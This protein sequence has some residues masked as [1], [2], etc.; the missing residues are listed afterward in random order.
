[1]Y[2]KLYKNMF[3]SG[4]SQKFT[5]KELFSLIFKV[6]AATASITEYKHVVVLAKNSDV[7]YLK[8][9]SG[10]SQ[11]LQTA[12]VPSLGFCTNP[13]PLSKKLH[14]V[15]KSI[16]SKLIKLCLLGLKFN[17]SVKTKV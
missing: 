16:D 10:N 12:T 8:H 17:D 14:S 2:R 7:S 9:S 1:M 13:E 15:N 4:F 6:T 11:E 5:H 3:N